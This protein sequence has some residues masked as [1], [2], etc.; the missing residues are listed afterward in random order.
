MRKLGLKIEAHPSSYK[1]AWL[2][3]RTEISVSK[4][5]LVSFSIGSYKDSISCD[6]VPMDTCHLLLGHPW[7]FDRDA[8]HKGRTNAYS[9]VFEGRNV[10]LLPSQEVQETALPFVG[11]EGGVRHLNPLKRC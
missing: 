5:A 1:L 2:N 10:T 11:F 8:T 3:T 4:K 9:F 7:Q 6:V